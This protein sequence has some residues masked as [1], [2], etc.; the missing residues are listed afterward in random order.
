[1]L[2]SFMVKVRKLLTL[3]AVS[4]VFFL[5]NSWFVVGQNGLLKQVESGFLEEGIQVVESGYI[6]MI[7]SLECVTCIEEKIEGYFSK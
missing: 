2:R 1:M 4:A 6:Y 5:L 3:K 7:Y